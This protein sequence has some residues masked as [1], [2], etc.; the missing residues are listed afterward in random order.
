MDA[1]PFS[2]VDANDFEPRLAEGSIDLQTLAE[3]EAIVTEVREQGESTIRKFA[4]QFDERTPDQPLLLGPDD[5]EAAAQRINH[6]DVEVL[7]R[8]AHRIETFAEAQLESLAELSIDVPGGQAG[9]KVVP[10]KRVGC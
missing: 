10:I 4:E 5:M 1:I 9:H 3:T 8:V 2:I 6:S 7:R